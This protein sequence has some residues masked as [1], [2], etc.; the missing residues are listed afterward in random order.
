MIKLL[1]N[2]FFTST[3]LLVS[4]LLLCVS[5]ASAQAREKLVNGSERETVAIGHFARSRALL[6]EALA[7]F[8]K[9]KTISD[10]SLIIDT[11][12]WRGSIVLR[13]EELNRVVAPKPRITRQG[14]SY[15]ANNQLTGFDKPSATKP[16]VYTPKEKVASPIDAKI[17]DEQD[18]K[19]PPAVQPDTTQQVDM[20]E[21][22][23]D[24]VD[25]NETI[26]DDDAKKQLADEIAN[27]D[28][29]D[30]SDFGNRDGDN[31]AEQQEKEVTVENIDDTVNVDSTDSQD[32]IQDI[33]ID[34]E[35]EKIIQESLGNS[36]N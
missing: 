30:D 23:T 34:A 10:P 22:L 5:N 4:A 15:E 26:V 32:E 33:D 24:D 25:E 12:R 28:M 29:E 1:R 11:E 21:N 7:E 17:S 6:I 8:E 18:Q 19:L 27:I 2:Y 36:D 31:T 14:I 3:T 20:T 35:V 13:A 9:G 16:L